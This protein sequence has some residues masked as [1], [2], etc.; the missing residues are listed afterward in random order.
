Q[1]QLEL[2]TAEERCR[3]ALIKSYNK[4]IVAT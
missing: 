3:A 1:M 2:D 4:Q